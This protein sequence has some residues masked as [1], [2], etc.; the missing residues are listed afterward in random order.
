MKWWQVTGLGHGLL[1]DKQQAITWTNGG[2]CYWYIT[3]LLGKNVL[4]LK[5]LHIVFIQIT[6][7]IQVWL[8]LKYQNKPFL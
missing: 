5:Y 3:V 4:T 8:L 2:E 7:R 6:L 1:L